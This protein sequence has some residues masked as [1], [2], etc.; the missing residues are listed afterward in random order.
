MTSEP[1]RGWL[2]LSIV[3]LLC[4]VVPVP[5]ETVETLYSRDMY[6]WLQIGFTSVSNLAPFA[7]LDA[8]ILIGVVLVVIRLWRSILVVRERGLF[9]AVWDLFRRTVRAVA[10][11]TILFLFAWGFNYRRPRL[12]AT[13]AEGEAARPPVASLEDAFTASNT[14]AARLR[15]TLVQHP[16][17]SLEALSRD[18]YKPFNIALT[19]IG[20][21]TLSVAG[22]PKHSMFV[23]PFFSKAG[24]DGMINPL[25]LESILNPEL[26]PFEQP[27]VLAHEWAHLAGQADEAEASAVGWLA[28]MHGGARMAYSASL[29]LMSETQAAMPSAARRAALEKIHPDVRTDLAEIAERLKKEDPRVSRAAF[30][31]YDEYLKANRVE[32]GKASYGRALRLILTKK[33]QDALSEYK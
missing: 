23:S 31:V 1:V 19:E 20:R 12:E 11:L 18:L 9:N 13:L 33:F 25:A 17:S 10:I 27:F 22:R 21:P 8:L 4:L 29:Y 3:A 5:A 2:V 24:V 15:P 7:V 26:L 14:L 28:C 32:D 16:D 6:P 30:R